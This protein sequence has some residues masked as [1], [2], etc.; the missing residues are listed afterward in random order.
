MR[1]NRHPMKRWK[2]RRQV[3]AIA[4][5]VAL[6]L[7]LC[8]FL[9]PASAMAGAGSAPV[10]SWGLRLCLAGDDSGTQ[11]AKQKTDHLHDQCQICQTLQSLGW[12]NLPRP[13]DIHLPSEA[14][15]ALWT[16]TD[17]YVATP[18]LAAGFSSRAPPFFA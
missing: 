5:F 14:A 11:P 2:M 12:A 10:E 8:A 3:A 13:I 1:L 17:L 16:A 6:F 7:Q 15:A 9:A 4:G 18:L